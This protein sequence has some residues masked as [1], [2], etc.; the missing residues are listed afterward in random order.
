MISRQK[1]EKIREICQSQPIEFLGLFGSMA[2]QEQTK[3]SDV[4]LLIRYQNT[5]HPSISDHV[6]IEDQLENA[7][8]RNVDLVTEKSL[9][10][11]LK[12][13]VYKDLITI[14]G[15]R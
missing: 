10:E 14:Y 5:S 1:I 12:P 9:N 4:D 7:L 15:K 2:R 6:R 11:R 13:Y 3:T 8:K